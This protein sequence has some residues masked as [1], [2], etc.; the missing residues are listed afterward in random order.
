M[1][2]S[3]ALPVTHVKPSQ[4]ATMITVDYDRCSYCGACVAICLQDCITLH[5]ATLLIDQSACSR[6]NR[7]L[8][9]C[10]TGALAQAP[11]APQTALA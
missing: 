4:A 10:P 2:T 9:A 3:A 8:H 11:L 6:C 5:D 1:L 7:C